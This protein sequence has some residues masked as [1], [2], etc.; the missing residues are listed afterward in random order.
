MIGSKTN[1]EQA[2]IK[3]FLNINESSSNPSASRRVIKV[4]GSYQI[5]LLAHS[6]YACPFLCCH[7]QALQSTRSWK[8]GFRAKNESLM[9]REMVDRIVGFQRKRRW[10]ESEKQSN[11]HGC[12]HSVRAPVGTSQAKVKVKP[13]HHSQSPTTPK[14]LVW[15]WLWPVCTHTF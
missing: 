1:L 15:D 13:R 4:L 14:R 12:V 2:M 9:I 10:W 8:C 11:F 6:I 3:L 5:Q 7:Y